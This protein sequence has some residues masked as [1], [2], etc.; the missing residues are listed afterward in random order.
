M[1]FPISRQCSFKLGGNVTSLTSFNPFSEED[2]HDQSS[3]VI[4]TSLFEKVKN[5]LAAPLSSAATNNS[6][7]TMVNPPPGPQ[8]ERPN[9]LAIVPSNPSPPLVSLMPVVSEAPSHN[10]E[11]ER[12]PSC[13]SHFYSPTESNKGLYGTAIPRFPIADD[14]RNIHTTGSANL[15]RTAS[16]SK[17]IRRICSEGGHRPH[18]HAPLSGAP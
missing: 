10:T 4:V 17:V 6:S 8:P 9:S 15:R 14:S 13:G 7:A 12:P 1:D 2:E 18:H 5:T 16:V 11:Y 3:Y